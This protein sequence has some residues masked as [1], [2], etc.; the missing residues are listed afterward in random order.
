MKWKQ[1]SKV[2]CEQSLFLKN[3]WARTQ[4]SKHVSV[5]VSVMCERWC[6]EPLVARALED[7]RKEIPDI[8]SIDSRKK[9]DTGVSFSKQSDSIMTLYISERPPMKKS[10]GFGVKWFRK[11]R[12]W[13]MSSFGYSM[14]IAM[15]AISKKTLIY[16]LLKFRHFRSVIFYHRCSIASCYK[17]QGNKII[18]VWCQRDMEPS[19]RPW[20]SADHV[21]D[22]LSTDSGTR[23]RLEP[24]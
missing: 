11:L 12:G 9:L 7:E 18:D 8:A 1:I 23:N 3:S 6:H 19:C 24:N 4:K 20:V 2:D 5:T 13:A 21:L 14:F 16:R 17:H 10:Q 15:H 22:I